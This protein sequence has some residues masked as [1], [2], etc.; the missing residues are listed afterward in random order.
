M[1]LSSGR[2]SAWTEVNGTIAKALRKNVMVISCKTTVLC[3]ANGDPSQRFMMSRAKKTKTAAGGVRTTNRY[4][5]VREVTS[6]TSDL[7]FSPCELKYGK[8]DATKLFGKL[9][10]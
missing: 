5:I 2:P 3:A 10:E 1:A 8:K 4:F 9:K 7:F 6:E